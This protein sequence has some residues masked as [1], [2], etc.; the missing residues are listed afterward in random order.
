[1]ICAAEERPP[2][3]KNAPSR[4]LSRRNIAIS[5][6]VAA[7][8]H[9]TVA[10]STATRVSAFSK[11]TSITTYFTM[12]QPSQAGIALPGERNGASLRHALDEASLAQKDRYIYM[13]GHR[14]AFTARRASA[15]GIITATRGGSQARARRRLSAMIF[16]SPA[17]RD[18]ARLAHH[19]L[20]SA[21]I[22]AASRWSLLAAIHFH[23]SY[24]ARRRYAIFRR[25]ELDLAGGQIFRRLCYSASHYFRPHFR[26]SIFQLFKPPA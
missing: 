15:L 16:L 10:I 12:S 9:S 11:I 8:S 4:V 20:R 3:P 22:F 14:P 5:H 23:Y 1:M 21:T 13:A 19:S 26:S 24:L 7:F 25:G 6:A 2:M 17:R 18:V